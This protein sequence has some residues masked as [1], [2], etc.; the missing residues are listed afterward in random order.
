MKKLLISLLALAT[1][2]PSTAHAESQKTPGTTYTLENGTAVVT[3][4]ADGSQLIFHDVYRAEETAHGLSLYFVD[5]AR[6]EPKA[7]YLGIYL[8][9][10]DTGGPVGSGFKLYTVD[11]QG[12][13]LKPTGEII[14]WEELVQRDL[15]WPSEGSEIGWEMLP[16]GPGVVSPA[17]SGLEEDILWFGFSNEILTSSNWTKNSAGV[18]IY[19]GSAESTLLAQPTGLFPASNGSW[20]RYSNGRWRFIK[21]NG[22]HAVRWQKIDGK[23]YYFKPYLPESAVMRTGWLQTEDGKWYYLG[24]DGAMRTGWLKSGTDWYYLSE[25]GAMAVGWQE[26]KDS[27]YYFDTD[28]RMLSSQWIGE[29]WLDENGVWTD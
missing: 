21:E 15:R 22:A 16:P 3:N 25:S 9:E 18:T 2:S 17:S 4:T 14:S 11:S 26:I 5:Q 23:W 7:N 27:W 6:Y 13:L 28:G 12:E 1:L 24:S 29:Y 10:S 19:I 20:E 8:A